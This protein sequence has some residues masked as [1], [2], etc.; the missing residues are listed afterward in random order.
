MVLGKDAFE[1]FIARFQFE[2]PYFHVLRISDPRLLDEK[3]RQ[4]IGAPFK[5]SECLAIGKYVW[6]FQT[7]ADMAQF[8]YYRYTPELRAKL[9]QA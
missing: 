2:F 9:V 7:P 8:N 3:V 1:V 6:M 5:Y 4:I